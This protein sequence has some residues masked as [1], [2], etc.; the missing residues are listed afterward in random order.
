MNLD[1]VWTAILIGTFP[2]LLMSV[3]LLEE[4]GTTR[5][6]FVLIVGF[7]LTWTALFLYQ[8]LT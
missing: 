1:Q 4:E 5:L 3:P 8:M 2:G 7:I 6:Q